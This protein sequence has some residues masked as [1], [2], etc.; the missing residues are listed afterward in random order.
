MNKMPQANISITA[1]QRVQEAFNIAAKP[2]RKG[3]TLIISIKTKRPV[4]QSTNIQEHYEGVKV[5]DIKEKFKRARGIL[6]LQQLRSRI[7]NLMFSV[8]AEKILFYHRTTCYM[9]G[10]TI[11]LLSLTRIL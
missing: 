8:I 3:A 1:E 7:V 2:K 5:N 10:T 6:T 4:Q 11:Q 9:K